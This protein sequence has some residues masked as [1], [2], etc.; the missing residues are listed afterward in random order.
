[1]E[2]ELAVLALR[3][4]GAMAEA[5]LQR[6]PQDHA[7]LFRQLIEV[8]LA[9]DA[10]DEAQD[11]LTKALA[12]HSEDAALWSIQ[13]RLGECTDQPAKCVEALTQLLRLQPGDERR[14]Q[15]AEAH[16]EI[17]SFATACELF[18]GVE[19]GRLR[20]A[21]I[22]LNHFAKA[23][24]CLELLGA[25]DRGS[26]EQLLLGERAS[27]R[28]ADEEGLLAWSMAIFDLGLDRDQD[29]HRV[30]ELVASKSLVD[31]DAERLVL[32]T[33][34][35]GVLTADPRVDSSASLIEEIVEI[36]HQ[37]VG[38]SA[39]SSTAGWGCT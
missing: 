6:R 22:H 19:A 14:L 29:A 27:R 39:E 3:D 8:R 24:R 12:L 23:E 2:I 15:L 10:F 7:A 16:L 37:P 31:D 30:C 21:A 4:R 34:T 11:L 25:P 9:S 38:V 5:L 35:P 26:A 17:A 20:A 36:D 1:M 28:V 33:D 18:E 13:L 32:L